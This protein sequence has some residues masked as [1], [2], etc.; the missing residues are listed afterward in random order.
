MTTDDMSL[1]ASTPVRMTVRNPTDALALAPVVLGF[2]PEDSVVLLTFGGEG[3]HARVDLPLDQAGRDD[4]VA[5]LT[6]ALHANTCRAAMVLA[7]SEDPQAVQAVT[8]ALLPALVDDLGLVVVDVIRADGRRWWSVVPHGEAGEVGEAGEGTAYDLRSH[9]FTADAVLRGSV[10]R[11]SREALAELLDAYDADAVEAVQR[12]LDSQPSTSEPARG[13]ARRL[14]ASW[15]RRTVERW[16]DDGEP[17]P[18]DEVARVLLLVEMPNLRDIVWGG[19]PRADAPRHLEVWL[20]VLRRTPFEWSASPAALVA[21]FAWLNGDGALAWT[22]VE[23][24]QHSDPD[25]S[26]ADLV[27]EAL[28]RAVPPSSWQPWSGEQ[29]LE[30]HG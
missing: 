25:N 4:V 15:L 14:V 8:E 1:S 22:A 20:Q 27:A 21:L 16:V 7:Y 3:F 29:L 6:D 19:V 13:P 12:A 17:G 9:P 23:K 28:D 11:A 24:S 2:H 30:V 5:V 18:A 26:L 10:V